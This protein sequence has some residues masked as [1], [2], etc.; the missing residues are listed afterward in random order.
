MWRHHPICILPIVKIDII[1]HLMGTAK[2]NDGLEEVMDG[3]VGK[4]SVGLIVVTELIG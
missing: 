1:T 4:L 2:G 3:E